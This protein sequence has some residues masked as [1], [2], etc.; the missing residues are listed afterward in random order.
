M[1]NLVFP[2]FRACL[3]VPLGLG[4]QFAQAAGGSARGVMVVSVQVVATCTVF[5]QPSAIAV[6]SCQ[7]R[8]PFVLH[9][10]VQLSQDFPSVQML[11]I[12]Y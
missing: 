12:R 4:F 2:I 3:L 7:D 6:A 8:T 5:T 10:E 9:R 11:T 1:P